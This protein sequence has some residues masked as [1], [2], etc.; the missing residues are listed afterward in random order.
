MVNPLNISHGA[1]GVTV[2]LKQL[3]GEVP[4]KF[5]KWIMDKK[6]SEKNYPPGLYLGLSGIAWG[7]TLLNEIDYGIKI[8]KKA[9]KH[10]M[11]YKSPDIY[12]GIA[13]FGLTNLHF[14]N[15]TKEQQYLDTA[16]KVANRLFEIRQR[17]EK[18]SFWY[19]PDKTVY[20]GY[21]RGASGISVF[22]LYL[23]QITKEKDFLDLGKDALN[24]DLNN[25]FRNVPSFPESTSN[26]KIALPY[27]FKGTAGVATATLRYAAL[28]G[29]NYYKNKLDLILT[30]VFKKYT[31]NPGLFNGLAGLGNT[32]ID[33][34]QFLGD[35]SYL[36]KAHQI[37]RGIY[38]FEIETEKGISFPGDF[39]LRKSNDFG[40]GASGI[41]LF[42][43]RLCYKGQNFNYLIDNL[44]S[45]PVDNPSYND[46]IRFQTKERV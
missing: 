4:Y 17:N 30:D 9:S 3:N 40:T 21:P 46:P 2:A 14:W 41:G 42:L 18:G 5:I 32:L 36:H 15:I 6:V 16:I 28:T 35:E 29:E 27:W 13:G 23:Y 8:L 22:L 1:V 20:I 43:H 37:G 45:S 38:L 11:L 33:A 24:F 34:Y 12:T 39:V 25:S 26:T 44:I 7:L 31:F 19:A 10:Q